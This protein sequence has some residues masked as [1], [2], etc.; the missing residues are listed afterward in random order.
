MTETKTVE[1]QEKAILTPENKPSIYDHTAAT[2][3]IITPIKELQEIESYVHHWE[4]KEWSLLP[5]KA[6][7][8]Y[9]EVAGFKWRVLLFPRGN[10][11]REMASVYLEVEPLAGTD[12]SKDWSVCAQF[13]IVISDPTDPTSYYSNSS[14]SIL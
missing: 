6:Q 5:D 8:P 9:F 12:S 1:A 13:G 7:G 10:N 14:P 3:Y 2:P 4:V 11:Q